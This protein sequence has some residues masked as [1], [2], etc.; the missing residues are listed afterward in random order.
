TTGEPST[1]APAVLDAVRALDRNVPADQIATMAQVLAA[2]SANRRFLALVVVVLAAAAI[3]LAGVG[4]YGVSAYTVAQRTPELGVRLA[5]GAR[6]ADVVA[7]VLRR[8]A[9]LT[10]A[11]LALGIAAALAATSIIHR[12]APDMMSRLLFGIG[13]TD[14]ASYTTVCIG[15]AV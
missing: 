3:L 15:V 9:A 14:V 10:A 7:L 2:S 5:L 12:A 13:P 6:P 4:L 1:L 11:G 8:G